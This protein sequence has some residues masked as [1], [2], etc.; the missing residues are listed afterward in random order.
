M[1]VMG[2]VSVP[3]G[4]VTE[5]GILLAA[6]EYTADEM[7]DGTAT[8]VKLKSSKLTNGRQFAYTVKNIAYGQART[9]LVYVVVDGVTYYS[10][11]ACT[12]LVVS[13]GQ[14]FGGDNIVDEDIMDPFEN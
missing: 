11:S 6:G 14:H 12:A 3:D 8:T 5:I 4:N 7:I 9:A 13:E 1:H 10:Q 2:V